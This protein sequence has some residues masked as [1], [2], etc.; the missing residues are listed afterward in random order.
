VSGDAAPQ[1]HWT[2][3]L[4]P[5]RA[6]GLRVG[7]FGGSFNPAHEGHRL[8]SLIALRRLKLDR[9]WWLMSPGNPLKDHRELA[10]LEV[11]MAEARRV[12]DHP[13]IDVTAVEAAL[14]LR[15]T[16]DVLR[17]LTRRCPGVRFVWIMGADNLANFPRWRDWTGI[18]RTMPIAIVD[19]PGATVRGL[20]GKA[21]SYL[22]PWRLPEQAAATLADHKPPA[23]MSLHGPRSPQSSTSLRAAALKRGG[24]GARPGSS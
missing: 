3:H 1:P 20:Q 24:R 5:R 21:W 13:K 2:A 15:Y 23:I 16:A 12:A 19:R 14:G 22:A 18:A 7:L 4:P 10:T 9:V 11:R 17:V 6:P 8:A